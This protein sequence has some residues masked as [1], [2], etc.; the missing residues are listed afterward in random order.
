MSYVSF[1]RHG[2]LAK[3]GKPSRFVA[4]IVMEYMKGGQLYDYVE[5]GALSESVARFFF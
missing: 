2:E 4:Y 3:A 5:A 1:K